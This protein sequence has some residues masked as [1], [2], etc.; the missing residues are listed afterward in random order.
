M[1]IIS[2]VCSCS[3][4][5]LTATAAQAQAQAPSQPA[6]NAADPAANQ[7]NFGVEDIVVT[8]NRREERQQDVPIAITTLTALAAEKQGIGGTEQLGLAV[9]SL[10]FSRQSANGGVPFLRGV[11]ATQA[12]AGGE[13]PVALYVDDVYVAAPA[14]NLFQFNNIDSIAVLKGPQGTLFG[15]NATGGVIQISTRQPTHE[16]GLDASAGYGNF[17]TIF[18]SLYATG[19]ITDT[20]AVNFS[21]TGQDQRNGYGHNLVTG[22]DTL[23]GWNYGFRG[24]LLWEPDSDTTL[25]LSGDYTKQR[26]DFGQSVVLMPGTVGAGGGVFKDKYGTYDTPGTIVDGKGPGDFSEF[27]VRGGSAKLTH[28]FGAFNVAMIT[29]ARQADNYSLLD[30]DGS[31]TGANLTA[32]RV[33]SR[34]RTF[35]QELQVLSPSGGAF[36]W[37]LGAYYFRSDVRYL[38]HFTFGSSQ[39]GLGGSRSIFS[40]QKLDS[41]SAFGEA[42]YEFLPETKLTVGLRYTSDQYNFQLTEKTGFGT[43]RPGTPTGDQSTFNKLTYRAI[44][45]HKFTPDILVYGSYSRGFKSGGYNMIA[46]TFAGAGG[47]LQLN[48]VVRPEVIDAYEVGIKSDLFDKLIRFNAAAYHYDYSNLQVTVF[49]GITAQIT[50]AASARMNGVDMDLNFVPSRYFNLTGGVSFLDSKFK[51]FEDGLITVP[52]P[53]TCTP[54]PQSTGPLTGGNST[55]TVDL[56]GNRT[57]RAPVFTLSIGATVTVPTSAGDISLNASLYHNPGFFWEADNRYRQPEYNLVNGTITWT[58][59]DKKFDVRVYGKNLLNEYYYSFLSTSTLRDAASPEMPR[60]YGVAVGVH[61]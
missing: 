31:G 8:A 55:C 17:D 61:F 36:N 23:K 3:L 39:A 11:G 25:L 6:T 19:G 9:P 2:L 37:I 22:A 10:Q 57:S 38:P 7:P 28:D 53:A 41:Y 51:N 44:L 21:A 33:H 14:G 24:K 59:P 56:S 5:A 54:T 26:G 35:S 58:S 12:S 32:A 16:F 49:R 34:V 15:R 50:N 1:K 13:A 18:G 29:A 20:I 43:T 47:V 45:D 4:L 60:T 52:N 40:T 30:I 46:P 48:P 27:V 42:S